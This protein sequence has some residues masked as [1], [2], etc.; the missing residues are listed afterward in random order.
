MIDF[1]KHFNS[2][3]RV[4]YQNLKSKKLYQNIN[5]FFCKIL[6][7]KI[8]FTNLKDLKKLKI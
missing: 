2:K 8:N 7:K 4:S 3:K 5:N 1:K 6:N